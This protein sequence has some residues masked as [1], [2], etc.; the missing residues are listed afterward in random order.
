MKHFT[1][2]IK[3]AIV[4]ILSIII[5]Y[6]GITFLKGMSIFSDSKTFYVTLPEVSGVD[7]SSQVLADGFPVGVVK[8][9][10]FDYA[11]NKKVTLQID[12]DK[13]LNIPEG[14]HAELTKEMLGT[15]KLNLVLADNQNYIKVGDTIPGGWRMGALEMASDLMPKAIA[16]F[17]K[18]DSILY[19]V[20]VIAN[21]PALLT[22]LNN[23]A[24]LTEQLKTTTTQ[25]NML[26]SKDM[27]QL[28][29]NANSMMEKVGTTT[30]K[31]NEVDFKG[32]SDNTIK[33]LEQLQEVTNEL[34]AALQNRESTYGKIMHDPSIY[35]HLD[36]T[37]Q[38]V[39]AL[40]NDLRENPKR[41]VHF[42]VFG[43]KDKTQKSKDKE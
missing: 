23:I 16:L 25:L 30:D 15:T 9:M 20:N 6:I 17:P 1:K 18:L 36:S 19:G 3:I 14:S 13:R 42:S 39:N 28:A 5:I 21:D 29:N 31:L 33:T 34:Q 4:A 22:S 38:S 40:M 10:S 11:T 24:E 7:V 43:K 12:V 32:L 41:Y 27:P 35:N 2:E 8:S 26:L 37:I